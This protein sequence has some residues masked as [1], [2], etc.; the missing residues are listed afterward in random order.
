MRYQLK[1]LRRAIWNYKQPLTLRPEIIGVPVSD[2]FV[3]RNTDEWKT[4][5]ELTDIPGLFLGHEQTPE[6]YV[7]LFFFDNEGTL[8]LEK[9]IELVP[10]QR[11]TLELSPLLSK[12]TSQ[13]GTFSVFHSRTPDMVANL[14]S[15]ISERGYVSYRYKGAPLRAYVHGN[16]DA[17]AMLPGKS[18]QLLG[19]RSILAREYRLQH[20]LRGPALYEVGIVNPSTGRRR[21]SCKVISARNGQVLEAHETQLKP[22]GCHVFPINFDH[23]QSGRIAIRSHLVMARP[24]MFRIQDIKMDVF[25]G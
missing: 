8:F 15:Y 17:I 13:Y 9:L 25:H 1:R 19:T 20:E 10:N 5:F 18:L 24:L 4:F 11:Q 6:P 23:L 12:S 3:W 7:T 14:G 21:I 16:L 22:R 2:L